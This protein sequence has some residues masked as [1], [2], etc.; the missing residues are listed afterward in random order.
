[1]GVLAHYLEEEGLATTQISLIREHTEIIKPPRAL[2]VPFDL[3]RPLGAPNDP[4]FQMKVLRKALELLEAPHGPVLM[5]FTEDAPVTEAQEGPLACPVSFAK[6]E[7]SAG[8]VEQMI[9]T[10]KQEV[11]QMRNWYDLAAQKRGRT[12]MGISGLTPEK[13]ADF[14]AA[15]VQ[16]DRETNPQAGV[17]LATALRMAVED[18][19]AYYLEAMTAQPGQSTNSSTLANWF[20]SQTMA[21][22]TINAIR[23][24]CLEM[25]GDE[26][27]ILGKFLLVP[28]NQL[29]HFTK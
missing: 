24:I 13:I 8:A 26:F 4:D 14:L 16:G 7:E 15:F 19:K 3:G 10:F 2:W 11:G 12:T 6:T 20:W 9:S 18:L 25:S 5:E 22:K 1:M 28:R 27:Q 23:E 29:H 21:A 17:P